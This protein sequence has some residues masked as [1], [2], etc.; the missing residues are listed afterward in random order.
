[1]DQ[2]ASTASEGSIR[3]NS[4]GRH[5]KGTD[6][7]GQVTADANELIA[8]LQTWFIWWPDLNEYVGAS[9]SGN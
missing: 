6:E 7:S 5:L 3:H 2:R 8:F 4:P 9:H 1:M